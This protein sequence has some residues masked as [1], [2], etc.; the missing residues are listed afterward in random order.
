MLAGVFGDASS[1]VKREDLFITSKLNCF[2]MH[3]NSVGPCLRKTLSDLKVAYLDL[4]LVHLPVP[5]RRTADG[6]VEP[7]R[8]GYSLC[9]TWRVLEAA[10]GLGLVRSIGVSNFNVQALNDLLNYARIKPAVNQIERH[11]YLQQRGTVDFCRREGIVVTAYASLGAPGLRAT[12]DHGRPVTPLLQNT[13]VGDIARRLNKTP[14]Q[15]MRRQPKTKKR[16]TKILLNRC[17]VALQNDLGAIPSCLVACRCSCVGRSIAASF[18]F[19]SR[20]SRSASP[21]T[22][23]CSTGSCRP[24]MSRA[25][26]RW[27]ATVLFGRMARA[28]RA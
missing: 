17:F 9:D 28:R 10:V 12:P 8:G 22:L 6:K 11:P 21:R 18:R 16:K 20:S 26:T 14:A 25:S 4:Y 13:L 1:G 2:Q 23:R 15:V 7:D 3:P 24:R 19:P 5:A 27:S